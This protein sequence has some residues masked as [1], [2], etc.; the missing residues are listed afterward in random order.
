MKLNPK[1]IRSLRAAVTYHQN[2][3]WNQG[4]RFGY[5]F[6]KKRGYDKGW[7]HGVRYERMRQAYCS[8]HPG[9]TD[10]PLEQRQDV[11]SAQY[12]EAF[13]KREAERE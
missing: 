9:E 12:A 11:L 13:P 3:L 10:M 7:T 4:Y 8:E 5:E 6:G 2:V 1:L